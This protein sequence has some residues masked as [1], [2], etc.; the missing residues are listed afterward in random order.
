MRSCGKGPEDVEVKDEKLVATD[1]WEG[2][3]DSEVM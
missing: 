1:G 2:S 3:V